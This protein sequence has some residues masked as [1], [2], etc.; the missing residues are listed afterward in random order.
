MDVSEGTSMANYFTAFA[1]IDDDQDNEFEVEC[2]V[3]E[4]SAHTREDPGDPGEVEIVAVTL[5]GDKVEGP[6]V[7]ALVDAN[8]DCIEEQAWDYFMDAQDDC[9]GD[10]FDDFDDRDDWERWA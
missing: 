8:L 3:Y 1:T 4:G 5:N 10:Y 7:D 6:K 9:D 2:R